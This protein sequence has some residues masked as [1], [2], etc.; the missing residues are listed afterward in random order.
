M[1]VDDSNSNS[2]VSNLVH[3]D[4]SVISNSDDGKSENTTP[5]SKKINSAQKLK[6]QLASAKKQEERLRLKEVCL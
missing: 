2:S 6:K 4:T 1:D 3:N 5:S